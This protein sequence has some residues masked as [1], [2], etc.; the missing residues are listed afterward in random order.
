MGEDKF[1]CCQTCAFYDSGVCDECE[2]ADQYEFNEDLIEEI[3]ERAA[4]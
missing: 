3:E 4:A 1:G 2:D